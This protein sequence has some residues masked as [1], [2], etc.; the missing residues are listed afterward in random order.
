VYAWQRLADPA[1]RSPYAALLSVVAGYDEARAAGDMTLLQVTA[2][3][4][5]TLVVVLSGRYDWFLTEVCTSPATSPLR[6]DVVQKLKDAAEER[7][8]RAGGENLRWWSDPTA[9]VCNGPYQAEFYTAGATLSAVANQRY[10]STQAG[11][12]TLVFHFADTAEE[13]RSLYDHKTVDAVWPLTEERMAELAVDE[14]WT[15]VPEMGTYAVLFNCGRE[16]LAD[17]L[18]RQAVHLAVDRDALTAAA[19]ISARA[20]GGL[21]PPGV[22]EGEEDFRTI[23]GALLDSGGE[24]YEE[25]RVQAKALLNEAGYDSGVSLGEMTYLYEDT[26]SNGAVAQMICQMWQEVLGMRVTPVGVTNRELW[27]A[28]RTGEYDLAGADLTAVGND[29]ECFLMNWTSDSTNNVVQYA[30]SAYD[31]LMAIIANAADSTARM[32][33]LHDAENLLISDCVMAPLYTRGTAWELRE[34]L[35][36]ACRDARGWF[37]FASVVARVA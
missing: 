14:T 5:N 11:P 2:K 29:A 10:Y 30:N 4:D 36:G 1:S 9:L 28:L 26:G 25:R 37:S 34:T 6:Q 17:Q 31:T 24:S 8:R 19:G 21:V 20:A 22:P 23:G 16:M 35:T 3:N 18:V 32:G 27:T 33:C 13:A 12:R 15:A 7:S